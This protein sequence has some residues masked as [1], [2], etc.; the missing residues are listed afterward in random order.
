MD[1]SVPAGDQVDDMRD[2]VRSV[3]HR[4]F[5]RRFGR[6]EAVS[7]DTS[8]TPALRLTHRQRELL[9]KGMAELR[10]LCGDEATWRTAA[11]EA[12]AAQRELEIADLAPGFVMW[13]TNTA[14]IA[15]GAW[16]LLLPG[17]GAPALQ[18]TMCAY[19]RVP[20]LQRR[21]EYA[22]LV[23]ALGAG[24]YPTMKQVLE[25]TERVRCALMIHVRE[26]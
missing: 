14:A 9:R 4:V 2:P 23:D 3:A 15:N 6:S 19:L 21:P 26:T 8:P 20:W 7:H 12:E 5:A 16:W 10:T 1:V 18:A 25:W 13:T 11:D 22:R 24:R 17:C